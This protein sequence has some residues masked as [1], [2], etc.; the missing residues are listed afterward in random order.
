MIFNILQQAAGSKMPSK[1]NLELISVNQT[2]PKPWQSRRS[3]AVKYQIKARHPE[4]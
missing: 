3:I 1:A 4:D 2:L